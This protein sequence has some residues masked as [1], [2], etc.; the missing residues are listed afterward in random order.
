MLLTMTTPGAATLV[1]FNHLLVQTYDVVLVLV[2]EGIGPSFTGDRFVTAFD[3][4]PQWR[5]HRTK[6]VGRMSR[7]F[8]Q[9]AERQHRHDTSMARWRKPPLQK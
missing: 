7:H 8:D 2:F 9:Q 5:F 6:F 1:A 4:H 3:S